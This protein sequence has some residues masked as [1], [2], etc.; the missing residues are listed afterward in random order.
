MALCAKNRAGIPPSEEDGPGSLDTRG[1]QVQR[2]RHSRSPWSSPDLHPAP[3]QRPP[4]GCRPLP[5]GQQG[6]DQA[7]A[8]PVAW[9]RCRLP[10][11]AGREKLEILSLLP[12]ALQ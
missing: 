10:R 2:P 11:L 12:L 1:P 4:V 9:P 3:A 8:L 6:T 5:G 7:A